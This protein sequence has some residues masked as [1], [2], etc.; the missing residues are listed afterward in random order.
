MGHNKYLFN[1]IKC[2]IRG[3]FLIPLVVAAD[4]QSAQLDYN[5]SANQVEIKT[6][7]ETLLVSPTQ[8]LWSI[9]HNS[10]GLADLDYQHAQID[11]VEVN[12]EWQIYSGKLITDQGIW[13]LRD[14]C[15]AEN[16]R[17]KCIR[18][19]HWTG[20]EQLN[21][22]VLSVRWLATHQRK[23]QRQTQVVM[24]S[25]VYHGNPSAKRN[26]PNRIA[27]LNAQP[28]EFVQY[29]EHR[30]SMPF[31][32]L[33]WPQSVTNKQSPYLGAALHTLP[34]ELS[35]ANRSDLWWSLGV[36]HQT[37]YTELRLLSGPIGYNR[38]A[39][40]SKLYQKKS[41]P[42]PNA[43]IKVQPGQIIEKTYYLQAYPVEQQGQGF[44]KPM[45]TSIDI[46]QPSAT[47]GYPEFDAIVQD[48]LR[49]LQSRYL[50]SSDYAGFNMFDNNFRQQIV[51][52]W[53]GQSEAPG[54]ALLVLGKKHQRKD[55]IAQ[56]QKSL[57]F[58]TQAKFADDYGFTV[59]YKIKQQKWQYHAFRPHKLF[60]PVSQ[61][62]AMYMFAK[63]IQVGQELNRGY[64]DYQ[65]DTSKWQ[66]FFKQAA[67]F[68]A[69]RIL[70]EDWQ[71][72]ST[73]EAFVIAPLALGA[74]LFNE[75]KYQQAAIKAGQHYAQ[76]HLSMQEPYWGG[77]LDAIGEDKEGAWGAFQAFMSLYDLTGETEYLSWA[78]HAANV[79]L[80][81]TV[82]WDIPMPAGR[83]ADHQFKSTGWTAVSPQN[84]HLDV[85][86][87]LTTPLLYRLAQLTNNDQLK[88]LAKVMYLSCGQLIDPMGSQGEQIQQTNFVQSSHN[89]KQAGDAVDPSHF[90]GGY[91]E[92]WTVL[93][94][95]AH[96][97][98][99]AAMFEEQLAKFD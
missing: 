20:D 46:F 23:L 98:T 25:L 86:G 66:T 30:F 38:Q 61:G 83:L 32:S 13:L 77:T 40:V 82:V 90:R 84:Q 7:S 36:E 18:R 94:I 59:S 87:V 29:E 56:A 34:S 2:F 93:W 10:Q 8:G 37:D 48:K 69:K 89:I 74:I 78:E 76:R 95:T 6:N 58:L 14:A 63:A 57:D 24:P 88:R 42:Y 22:I 41:A 99:A 51:M 70:K 50:E 45:Q 16:D 52:G 72:V 73:N 39:D 97:L 26:D 79:M 96:F 9:A 68:H 64:E 17:I 91:S 65:V 11:Q 67:D 27:H 5:Q 33:E 47:Q 4:A 53:A 55:W 60:D 31:V 19:Y 85:Y 62:Q 35:H 54:Y 43:T 49:F 21:N 81:Y 1:S 80:T 3:L 44:V 75:P 12:G 92:E 28:G 71:P 15:K